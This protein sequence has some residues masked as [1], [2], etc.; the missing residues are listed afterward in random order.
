MF[1]QRKSTGTGFERFQVY[2]ADDTVTAGICLNDGQKQWS[3]CMSCQV[4]RSERIGNNEW[5]RV[6]IYNSTMGTYM[7]VDDQICKFSSN[8]KH[9]KPE[10]FYSSPDA[11]DL[12]YLFVG[13]THYQRNNLQTALV[14]EEFQSNFLDYGGAT[15]GESIRVNQ[16]LKIIP[17][18]IILLVGMHR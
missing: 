4:N 5:I 17:I 8:R 1:G 3:P 12:S 18:L 10:M 11:S 9:F 13:G 7:T 2:Y 14:K 15:K 16:F 6:S